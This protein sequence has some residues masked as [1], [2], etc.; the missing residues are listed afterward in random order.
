MNQQA[1]RHPIRSENDL[2]VC[3]SKTTAD[4]CMTV[5]STL[6]FEL[7]YWHR[8]LME[9][10][11]SP[12][13]RNG[14][15]AIADGHLRLLRS[16]T[17][18]DDIRQLPGMAELWSSSNLT[19]MRTCFPDL[20][21]WEF[22]NLTVAADINPDALLAVTQLDSF[23]WVGCE[24]GAANCILVHTDPQDDGFR[25]TGAKMGPD[26]KLSMPWFN[27][28]LA[29]TQRW[30][31]PNNEP[32]NI[33]A[34]YI[35]QQAWAEGV[36]ADATF[37][38]IQAGIYEFIAIRERESQTMY[39]SDVIRPSV[40]FGY[41]GM[42]TGL[43][44]AIF[45]EA[46]HRV[47]LLDKKSSFW[48]RVYS[49]DPTK[50]SSQK[51]KM[52]G[53]DVSARNI[54]VYHVIPQGTNTIPFLVGHPYYRQTILDGVVVSGAESP[55]N[56]MVPENMMRAR[57]YTSKNYLDQGQSR[58]SCLAKLSAGAQPYTK[59]VKNIQDPGQ[60]FTKN[61]ADTSSTEVL[62][63][64]AYIYETL[65]PARIRGIPKCIGFFLAPSQK[66]NLPPYSA[67]LLSFAGSNWD[68]PRLLTKSQKDRFKNTL[69]AIHKAGYLHGNLKATKLLLKGNESFIVGLAKAHK[70]SSGSK[71]AQECSKEMRQLELLLG[72]N[73]EDAE[74]PSIPDLRGKRISPFGP[75]PIL[76]LDGVDF[77]MVFSSERAVFG[78][79]TQSC[80]L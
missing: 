80:P 37:I 21:V 10:T 70:K 14:G 33:K 1:L 62:R 16:R 55:G 50:R 47:N 39:I 17:L 20:S 6:E 26:V 56:S 12:A 52:I 4:W 59:G 76:N 23:P 57:V 49:G 67:L 40:D 5:A 64:E 63:R 79:R 34:L 46:K 25:V 41:L 30:N 51:M 53:P 32:I 36:R 74:I 13:G 68:D 71:G 31:N 28:D 45:R 48:T 9:W 29:A 61:S 78:P 2:A 65:H 27:I 38:S 42:E 18:P 43:Y 15:K 73:P 11:V 22:K 77:T 3:Y 24:E 35:I 44:M 8:G 54:L 66:L 69:R 19:D 60:V 75:E 7:D 58:T 72:G